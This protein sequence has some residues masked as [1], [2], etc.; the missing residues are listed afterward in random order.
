MCCDSLHDHIMK[1]GKCGNCKV[2]REE[3]QV[4][5]SEGG[6]VGMCLLLLSVVTVGNQLDI[7]SSLF[8]HY[9]FILIAA[10]KTKLE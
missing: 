5:V 9:F 3:R 10:L 1:C 8:M 7:K 2:G 6:D 4:G